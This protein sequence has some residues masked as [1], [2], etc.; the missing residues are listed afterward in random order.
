MEKNP[1]QNL[2]VSVTVMPL[3]WICGVLGT[4]NKPV[5]VSFGISPIFFV[6]RFSECVHV[7]IIE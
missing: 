5:I 7:C 3:K 6:P 2:Y 1:K 4:N